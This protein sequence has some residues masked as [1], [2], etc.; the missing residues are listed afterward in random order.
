MRIRVLGAGLYGLHL[1]KSLRQNGCKVSVHE[2]ADKVFAGATGN[3]PARLHMGQHY[4]RSKLTRSACQEHYREFME[5][6]GE[7]THGIPCNIY[8][9]AESDSLVDF[10]TYRQVLRDEIELITVDRPTELGLQGV[11]GAILTGERHVLTD[12][13]AGHFF[14]CLGDV[15]EFG[16]EPGLVDDPEWDLTIDATSCAYEGL[17]VDRYE[18]CLTVLLEGPV[19]KAITIVDGR[20]PSLYVWDEERGLCSLT[21]AKWTPLGVYPTWG[22]ARTFLDTRG[23]EAARDHAPAMFGQMARYYPRIRDEYSIV[24]HRLAIRAMPRSAADA[25]LVDIVR[26]G[27]RAIRIRAGKLDAIF[28]AERVIRGM[29]PEFER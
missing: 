16:R 29:L 11:E 26:V 12:K 23:Q 2:I 5:V 18:A 21:S 14:S 28:H 3:I 4:V 17:A 7:Y 20:F 6:Y 19:D 15:I 24:D 8:A 25:R 1:A 13:L 22:E 10:G 9:V 27:D